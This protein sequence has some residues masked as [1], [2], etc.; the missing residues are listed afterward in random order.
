MPRDNGQAAQDFV[1]RQRH[2]DYAGGTHEKFLWLATETFGGVIDG[3]QRGS[4]ADCTRGA[5]GV[6]GIDDDGAHA[7]FGLFKMFTGDY[8]R[9]GGDQILREDGGSAG[10]DLA[11]KYGEVECTG[12]FQAASCGCETKAT[13]QGRF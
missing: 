3:A 1:D 4:V 9:G 10:G 6:A 11:G 12:F 2:A 8:H 13:W 7:A 5:I